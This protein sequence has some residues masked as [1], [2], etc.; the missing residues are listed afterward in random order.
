MEFQLDK[1]W[2]LQP[3]KGAT[4]QERL[5]KQA[6]LLCTDGFWELIEEKKMQHCLKKG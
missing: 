5:G 1:D 6:F 2:R 4:G 3:I